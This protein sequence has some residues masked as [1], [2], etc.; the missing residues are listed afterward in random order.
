MTSEYVGNCGGLLTCPIFLF[1]SQSVQRL[2]GC[3]RTRSYAALFL[4]DDYLFFENVSVDRR[5]HDI[6]HMRRYG[7]GFTF[8]LQCKHAI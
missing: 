2:G 5:V 1:D 6:W 4:S 3:S 7:Y 8:E